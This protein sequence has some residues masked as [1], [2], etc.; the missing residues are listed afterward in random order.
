VYTV[1]DIFN[2]PEANA[3]S[4]LIAAGF[5]PQ[6]GAD[7][8]DA[9]GTPFDCVATQD[10][11]AGTTTTVYGTVVVYHRNTSFKNAREN[12]SLL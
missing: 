9:I 10:T 2:W 12:L 7:W 3:V 4:A 11:P 8:I 5:T 1:P 6:R